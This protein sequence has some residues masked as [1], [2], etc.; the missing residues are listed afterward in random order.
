MLSTSPSQTSSFLFS[1]QV[2]TADGTGE[3]KDVGSHPSISL[4]KH[5]SGQQ[6]Q[7]PLG[8]GRMLQSSLSTL[9]SEQRGGRFSSSVSR[10]LYGHCSMRSL[11][12]VG[13]G[14]GTGVG[15]GDGSG[16]GS[17]PSMSLLSVQIVGTGD[18]AG[19]GIGVG[20]QP[21]MSLLS[22]QIVGTGDGAEEG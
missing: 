12:M 1:T 16:V 19:D 22:L 21:S 5:S 11:Q 2:G 20:S 15:T 18:G 4:S 10:Q 3:G 8:N 14:D 6:L 17:H 7:S 9:G 13:T